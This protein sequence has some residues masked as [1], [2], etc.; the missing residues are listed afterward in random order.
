MQAVAIAEISV[1]GAVAQMPIRLSLQRNEWLINADRR[2]ILVSVV[3]RSDRRGI[4]MSSLAYELD[5]I[6]A[7]MGGREYCEIWIV[8]IVQDE[9]Y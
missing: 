8:A 9:C 1:A 4:Q 6:Q 5:I 3:L 7:V 2:D